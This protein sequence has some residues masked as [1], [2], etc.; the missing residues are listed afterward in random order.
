M[1]EG[2]ETKRNKA[3]QMDQT[4]QKAHPPRNFLL[5]QTNR[6]LLLFKPVWAMF[7]AI[8]IKTIHPPDTFWQLRFP[9]SQAQEQ[10]GTAWSEKIPSWRRWCVDASLG[11]NLLSWGGRE[12]QARSSH[13][14]GWGGDELSR[15]AKEWLKGCLMCLNVTLGELRGLGPPETGAASILCLEFLDS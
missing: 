13:S 6:Q 8:A 4:L 1:E 15:S 12:D 3:E 10:G 5:S 2:G 11:F 7:S 14:L 9:V